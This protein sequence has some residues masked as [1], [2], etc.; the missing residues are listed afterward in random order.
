[1]RNHA[2]SARISPNL[3]VGS[4]T[5]IPITHQLALHNSARQLRVADDQP[6]SSILQVAL[7]KRRLEALLS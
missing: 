1:M 7:Q 5:D 6:H 2:E 4:W 3:L